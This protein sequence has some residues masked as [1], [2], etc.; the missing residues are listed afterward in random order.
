M[1]I[2]RLRHIQKEIKN[3][4]IFDRD[5]TLNK[6]Y[7]YTFKSNELELTEFARCIK[8]TFQDFRFAAA[9]A[10]NQSGIARQFFQISDFEV[11]TRN[12]T[13]ELD[14][15]GGSFFLVAACPH[16]PTAGCD[17]R[18]PKTAM[19]EAITNENDF[20]NV[21]M[22]GNSS[23]DMLAAKNLGI[24]YI[25]CNKVDSCKE[26]KEWVGIHCDHK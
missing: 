15:S 21:I 25:D 19:L 14:P 17:C 3:L 8:E 12:L 18:K 9:I 4:I 22:V 10:S 13:D 1:Q 11:F 6:D 26:F 5:G 23:S 7:G 24:A 2:L 16:L 20:K